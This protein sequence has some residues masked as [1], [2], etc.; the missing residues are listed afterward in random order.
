[1]TKW[2]VDWQIMDHFLQ[3]L[4]KEEKKWK[5]QHSTIRYVPAYL[6]EYFI[7]SIYDKY[8]FWIEEDN[9]G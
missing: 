3:N 1:M 2:V 4:K 9:K 8:G 6:F 5:E 7:R